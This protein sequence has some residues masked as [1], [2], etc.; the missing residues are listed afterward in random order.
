M[1]RCFHLYLSQV[2]LKNGEDIAYLGL[3]SWAS[4]GKEK[5]TKE[6]RVL[7]SY[8]SAEHKEKETISPSLNFYSFPYSKHLPEF[9]SVGGRCSP[10][11]P[12]VMA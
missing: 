9:T 6:V 12:D 1:R 10:H 2:R 11:T 8:I 7:S 4:G 3:W 5:Q